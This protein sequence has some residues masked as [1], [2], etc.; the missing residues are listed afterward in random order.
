MGLQQGTYVIGNCPDWAQVRSALEA[1]MGVRVRLVRA[2]EDVVT[3][4]CWSAGGSA[5][6]WFADG[7]LEWEA[8]LS[9]NGYF[10]SHLHEAFVSA[11]A[12]PA[13]PPAQAR[14]GAGVAW[15]DLPLRRR[16]AYGVFGQVARGV[17]WILLLP[18]FLVGFVLV[19]LFFL[20]RGAFRRL[21]RR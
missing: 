12:K 11:G 18:L 8:P 6:C 14:E 20:V 4:S 21:F 15:R 3:L 1:S 5:N 2:R 10:L 13:E 16:L 9:V 17:F 19:N 7:H